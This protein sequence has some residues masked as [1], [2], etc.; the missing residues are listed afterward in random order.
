MPILASAK[1]RRLLTIGALT[2][3]LA[4]PMTMPSKTFAEDKKLSVSEE[5][6]IKDGL[7]A[8]TG[9]AV[10]LQ[11]SSGQDVSGTIEE[12]GPEVVRIGQ[13]SGKE[14]YSALVS[15]EEISAL[16]YRAK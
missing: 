9:K 8:L 1:L 12:V 6:A 7:K 13:L 10:T 2:F 14:F 16:I 5:E 15:I 3:S 11:L 4:A